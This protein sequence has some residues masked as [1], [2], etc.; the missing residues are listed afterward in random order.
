[1][2]TYTYLVH[3]YLKNTD[4]HALSA[5]EAISY[6]LHYKS[7]HRLK[8]YTRWEISFAS[9]ENPD[10]KL[11]ALLEDSFSLINVNKEA[12]FVGAFPET[13]LK[14]DDHLFRVELFPNHAQE[15]QNEEVLVQSI[16]KKT[17]IALNGLKKTLVWEL[18]VTDSRSREIVQADLLEKVILTTSRQ[19]GLLVS[20]LYE[21][22]RFI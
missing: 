15:P 8:R 20:P 18:S 14:P 22:A 13:H 12:Y 21:I 11:K 3:T 7:I 1:M 10:N 6:Y 9:H 19:H 5:Y 17:E 2:N 4:L 16:L